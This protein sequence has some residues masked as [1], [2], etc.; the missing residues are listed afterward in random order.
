MLSLKAC[1]EKPASQQASLS[2]DQP[3]PRRGTKC[4][5]WV[6]PEELRSSAEGVEAGRRSPNSNDR[7]ASR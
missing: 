2:G 3:V 6:C 5:V 1:R 7:R 4:P